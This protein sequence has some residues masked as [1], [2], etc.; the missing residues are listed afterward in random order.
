M[1]MVVRALSMPAQS[2]CNAVFRGKL[3]WG[4]VD[5]PSILSY[6]FYTTER[7]QNL[8]CRYTCTPV[9]VETGLRW[10]VDICL[11][12]KLQLR[13][14]NSI[15]ACVQNLK[16]L[17]LSPVSIHLHPSVKFLFKKGAC[18]ASFLW[19][20]KGWVSKPTESRPSGLKCFNQPVLG[21]SGDERDTE[22]MRHIAA[23]QVKQSTTWLCKTSIVGLC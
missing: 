18:I 13:M 2:C 4:G 11:A 3:W 12:F 22:I 10:K 1:D 23:Y 17:H 15:W 7:Q 9:F 21:L 19:H 8:T 20:Q 6:S 14:W 16:L 5:T